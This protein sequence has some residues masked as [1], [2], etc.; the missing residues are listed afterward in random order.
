MIRRSSMLILTVLVACSVPQA[1]FYDVAALPPHVRPGQ[2]L[3]VEAFHGGPPNATA[4]RILY[5]S[6][7]P[8]GAPIVQTV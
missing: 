7:T 4:R 6:T 3:R 2:L 8:D 1:E 5:G